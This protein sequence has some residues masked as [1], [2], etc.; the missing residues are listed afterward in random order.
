MEPLPA[1]QVS[2]PKLAVPTVSWVTCSFQRGLNTTP[3][4]TVE[5]AEIG[6]L[7]SR[8]RHLFEVGTPLT[9]FTEELEMVLAGTIVS[10]PNKGFAKERTWPLRPGFF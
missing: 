7:Q 2:F 6:E 1:L 3:G 4:G 9:R 10:D 8:S 5:L